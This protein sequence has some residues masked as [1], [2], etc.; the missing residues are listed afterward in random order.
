M[1]D[2]YTSILSQAQPG[3]DPHCLEIQTSAHNCEVQTRGRCPLLSAEKGGSLLGLAL[4]GRGED[5][6]LGSVLS[7]SDV[8]KPQV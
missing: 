4:P 6:T 3:T 7:T 8:Q 5:H 1:K 2:K